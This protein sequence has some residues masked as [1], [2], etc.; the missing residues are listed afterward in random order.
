MKKEEG[1]SGSLSEERLYF[2]FQLAPI[3]LLPEKWSRDGKCMSCKYIM[4]KYCVFP[5]WLF[6]FFI[7][8][9]SQL[10]AHLSYEALFLDIIVSC[11]V[12]FTTELQKSRG[13][14][15]VHCSCSCFLVRL[16]LP[17]Q[18]LNARDERG[19]VLEHTVNTQV[20]IVDVC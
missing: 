1:N 19:C 11:T 2:A 20:V 14:R 18:A 12:Y 16:F 17:L 9:M 13:L 8:E 5:C 7:A 6:V 15:F 3:N 10:R 4:L